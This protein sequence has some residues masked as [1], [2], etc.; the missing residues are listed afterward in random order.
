MASCPVV[1]AFA[2][3]RVQIDINYYQSKL[4]QLQLQLQLQQFRVRVADGVR[5]RPPSPSSSSFIAIIQTQFLLSFCA[6]NLLASTRLVASKIC[7]NNY[8]Q[9]VCNKIGEESNK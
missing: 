2:A 5:R 9:R 8:A 6:R 3:H 4:L 1:I 7:K